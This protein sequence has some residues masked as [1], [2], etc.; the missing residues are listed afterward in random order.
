M[1][2]RT[3]RSGAGGTCKGAPPGGHRAPL[4]AA[5]TGPRGAPRMDGGRLGEGPWG[6][7]SPRRSSSARGRVGRLARIELGA[8]V[9]D[10]LVGR[11]NGIACPQHLTHCLLAV[12]VVLPHLG[13]K[14]GNGKEQAVD[15]R[16]PVVKR[17]GVETITL[18]QCITGVERA[19]MPAIRDPRDRFWPGNTGGE[20]QLFYGGAACAAKPSPKPGLVPRRQRTQHACSH[21]HPQCFEAYWIGCRKSS[22]S[23]SALTDRVVGFFGAVL[24]GFA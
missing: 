21:P 13:F 16:R 12:A 7:S 9:E 6:W 24:I 10:G 1:A 8:A 19:A 22:A 11:H 23:Y 4:V 14:L 15:C 17:I 2:S 3:E 18:A 20:H 5:R